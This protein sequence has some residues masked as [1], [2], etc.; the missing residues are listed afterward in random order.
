MNIEFHSILPEKAAAD[1]LFL[2]TTL[3]W[4]TAFVAALDRKLH[5][6][7]IPEAA[8]QRFKGE[9]GEVAVF[10]THGALPYR[11]VFLVGLGR[12]EGYEIWYQL[13]DTI[14]Q[15]AREAAAARAAL[16]LPPGLASLDAVERLVEGVLLARYEFSEFKEQPAH[17]TS[18][19]Q[20]VLLCEGDGDFKRAAQRGRQI[21]TAACYARDLVNR[22]SALVTP[23]YLANEAKRL[24][25]EH[26]LSA[27]I[28]GVDGLRR[29]RMGCILGVGQG[30]AEPPCF[31][32]LVYRPPGVRNPPKI[33]LA[34]KGITFDSGGLSLKSA[35]AMTSMKRDMAGAA[36]VLA[37]LS[38][39]RALQLP[40][41]VRGYVAAAENMPS[42]SALR[43][44]DVLRARNGKTIEVLNTDAEGRLV[45]ADALSYAA[46]AK[47]DAIVDFA[48]LTG[49]VRAALGNRYAAILGTDRG[50]VERLRRA[51]EASQERLW[52]LPLPEDYRS[53]LR[54]TVADLKNVGE[55]GAG[56]I[57]AALFLRE[58]VG[59]VPWAH[60]DFSSTASTDKPFPC[61][62]RGATGF[63]VRTALRFLAEAGS[64]LRS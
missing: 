42:G 2:A 51:G 57:V 19:A 29:A 40:V 49:T 47:P 24:A 38:A 8:A 48:T 32:E 22:P 45:L 46:A 21:A 35:E 18:L 62:P 31:I 55:G 36:V 10:Q 14:V 15:R 26:D 23:T 20:L 41:E 43:P 13:A 44:G 3:D 28:F 52:E 7:L 56:T 16:A 25:R 17:A 6:A 4:K 33:A 54:S 60:I 34:G 1:V 59:E 53:E 9:A 58:F 5:G 63:G 61:H 39:A 12:G 27:R 50:L 30:S 11:L 37:V 64:G